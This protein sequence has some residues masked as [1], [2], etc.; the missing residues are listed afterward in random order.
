MCKIWYTSNGVLQQVH[1]AQLEIHRK[2]MPSNHGATIVATTPS[3]AKLVDDLWMPS[4]KAIASPFIENPEATA[5]MRQ[6]DPAIQS[7][8]HFVPDADERRPRYSFASHQDYL[9][10]M[11]A[12]AGR[13]LCA[14]IGVRSI[15]SNKTRGNACETGDD[16]LQVWE[17]AD[18]GSRTVRFFRGKNADAVPQV[19][20][21]DCNCL[22]APEKEERGGKLVFLLRDVRDGGVTKDIKYLKIAFS[23]RQAEEEFLDAAGIALHVPPKS[24]MK[25][26]FG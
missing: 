19:V 24:R 23:G 3:G 14:S 17:G 13:R 2:S 6:R 7:V 9:E 5:T 16:T 18:K 10:F 12:I 26:R 20:E 22:R 1:V 8:V 4:I 15:K 11:Q 21:L 25:S